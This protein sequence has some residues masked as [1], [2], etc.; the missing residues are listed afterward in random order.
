MVFNGMIS[1]KTVFPLRTKKNDNS[2]KNRRSNIYQSNASREFTVGFYSF[3]VITLSVTNYKGKN[4]ILDLSSL[5]FYTRCAG[6]T[7]ELR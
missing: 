7:L 6:Y 4:L 3:S 1:L 5:S 2:Y